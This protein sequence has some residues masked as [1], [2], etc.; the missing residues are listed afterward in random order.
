[1]KVLFIGGTG[2]LSSDCTLRALAKGMEVWHLNRGSRAAK[3]PRAS[4]RSAD[5]R[6]EAAAVRAIG[7]EKF[8]AVVDFVAFTSRQIEEDIRL[9]RDRTQS[10]RLHQ[11][12]LSLPKA[13]GAPRDHGV[14][15]PREPILEVF[16]G[17][18]RVREAPRGGGAGEGLPLHHR[19]ALAHLLLEVDAHRL[20]LGGLHRAPSACWTG[21]GSSSTATASR[22]GR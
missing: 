15:A 2:N 10:V 9:F 5:I 4:C 21:G 22:S 11:L 17:Q 18:D 1:M 14:D 7:G 8:D 6:D 20:R 13:A 16:S 12:G 19:A 3:R